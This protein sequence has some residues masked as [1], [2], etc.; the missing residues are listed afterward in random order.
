VRNGYGLLT[1]LVLGAGLVLVTR[2]ADA[3][4]Q[5]V[6]AS[7]VA[8]VLLLAA[9]RPLVDLLR[10]SKASRR[11]SDPDQ[12]ARLTRV[13]AVLWILVLLVANL[14]GLVWGT[15]TLVPRL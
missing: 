13:P 10:R 8:W 1:V 6:L 11:G 14:A 3:R 12:L 5:A 2:Y 9:P 15:A 7:L 4:H